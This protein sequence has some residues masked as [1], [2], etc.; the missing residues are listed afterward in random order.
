MPMTIARGTT[1]SCRRCMKYG[2][3]LGLLLVLWVGA[4]VASAAAFTLSGTQSAWIMGGTMVLNAAEY[5]SSAPF[6]IQD[7]DAGPDF[8][9][10]RS[11]INETTVGAY[12]NL[13]VGCNGR[14]TKND[15][16][17]LQLSSLTPGEVTS[18]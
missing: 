11:S 18:S 10:T 16:F 9:I 17:P 5:R 2:L 4:F 1:R 8:T 13:F 3:G 7:P 12:P 6:T 14:C 15:P